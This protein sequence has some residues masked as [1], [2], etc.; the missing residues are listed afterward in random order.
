[1]VIRRRVTVSLSHL[2]P[3]LERPSCQAHV[4][5]PL[6]LHVQ[7]QVAYIIIAKNCATTPNCDKKTPARCSGLK[8]NS[9]GKLLAV[10]DYD[11]SAM[12]LDIYKFSGSGASMAWNTADNTL[13]LVIARGMLNMHQAATSAVIDGK[14]MSL[15]KVAGQTASHSF[16]NSLHV[17]KDGKFL[18][19]DLGDNFPRGINLLSFSKTSKKQ[20]KV[21]Y[22]FKTGHCAAKDGVCYGKKRE[23]YKE[24]ST[25]TKTYYQHS[26][27][28]RVRK[29]L[30][31]CCKQNNI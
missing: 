18:G 8:V 2:C 28:N 29:Y 6:I 27:D 23:V 12:G 22:T 5:T 25:D 20:S 4:Y 1:M 7:H 30:Q 9:E 16:S 13:G 11:T 21:V 26:N 17:G 24:I 14:D 19:A 10:R 3:L 31:H 15:V